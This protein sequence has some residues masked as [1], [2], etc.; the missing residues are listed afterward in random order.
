MQYFHRS[1]D[2]I[3]NLNNNGGYNNIL[4]NFADIEL[5]DKQIEYLQN[6][7]GASNTYETIEYLSLYKKSPG[8]EDKDDYATIKLWVTDNVIRNKNSYTK[9]PKEV[10]LIDY[11]QY[12]DVGN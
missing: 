7:Y 11:E 6:E 8:R 10:S 9:K 2:L 4:E 5:T 1:L 3:M 12:Y